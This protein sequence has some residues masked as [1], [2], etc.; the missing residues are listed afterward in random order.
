MAISLYD[1][2]VASFLQ[3]LGAVSGFLD[4]GLKYCG[5]NGIDPT[6]I[7]ER[8]LHHDML[9]LSFQIHS[10]AAHSAGAI[11]SIRRGE[12]DLPPRGP[13][14]YA[15]LQRQVADARAALAAETPESINALE[16]RHVALALG[17]LAIRFTAENYLLSFA[18][19]N[20][21]FHATTAY[22]ILRTQGVPI[23]KRH[24]MGQMRTKV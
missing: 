10:V 9:P 14:D 13:R 21:Y 3:T 8:R 18:M 16:G 11:A 4:R 2:T 20:F 23:G 7:V 5:E 19:P 17:D 1:A 15:G 6:A 24:F 12:T 22:D